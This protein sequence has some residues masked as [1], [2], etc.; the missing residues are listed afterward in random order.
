MARRHRKRAVLGDFGSI[1]RTICGD[2]PSRV[3][4]G[5]TRV[6]ARAFRSGTP[7]SRVQR[8]IN[9]WGDALL[10][11]ERD[12]PQQALMFGEH[13]GK[14][15]GGRVLLEFKLRCGQRVLDVSDEMHR[16]R[17]LGIPRDAA[18]LRFR[19]RPSFTDDMGRW[20]LDKRAESGAEGE[21]PMSLRRTTALVDPTDPEFS[22]SEYLPLLAHYAKDRGYAAVRLADEVAILDRNAI[23]DV[24]TVSKREREALKEQP[25]RCGRSSGLFTEGFDCP[26]TPDLAKRRQ[27]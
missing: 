5:T 16:T 6:S 17:S 19:G 22:G 4:H 11:S 20:L 12:I 9:E 8:T 27:R 18:P 26:P 14:G 3:L 1:D 21:R 24:R 23:E 10:A 13:G 2:Y 25:K 15:F 7:P